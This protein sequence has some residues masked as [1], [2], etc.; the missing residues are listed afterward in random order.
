MAGLAPANIRLVHDEA[1]P[2]V[3]PGLSIN[4][5][6]EDSRDV[7]QLDSSGTVVKI[8]NGVYVPVAKFQCSDKYLK[9]K[10]GS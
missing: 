6:S 1:G 10:S 3:I 9:A 2:A 7:P 8:E 4:H 5:D